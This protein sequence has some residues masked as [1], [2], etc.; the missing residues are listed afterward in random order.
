MRDKLIPE[1][2]DDNLH[3]LLSSDH[4][5]KEPFNYEEERLKLQRKLHEIR[6]YI[7]KVDKMGQR[8]EAEMKN[9]L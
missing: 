4:S 8:N 6:K 1:I 7:I 9:D 2:Q 3:E 5:S